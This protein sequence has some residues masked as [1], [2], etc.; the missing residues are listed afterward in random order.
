M[1]LLYS[2]TL[3]GLEAGLADKGVFLVLLLGLLAPQLAL[4]ARAIRGRWLPAAASLLAAL[5]GVGLLVAGNAASGYDAA[6]PRPDTLFYAFN[7]DRGEASWATLDPEPDQ[8]TRQFLSRNTE[9]R[10]VEELFGV[11][12]S[13]STKVLTGPAPVAPLKPPEL[14]LLGQ[15]EANVTER[16]LR[17]HLSSPRGAWKAYL[18]FRVQV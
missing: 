3:D 7:A 1:P 10:S 13:G 16:V 12:G 17:L 11:G 4:I 18:L 9:E 15:E 14:E 5:I 2:A 6:H 8:W